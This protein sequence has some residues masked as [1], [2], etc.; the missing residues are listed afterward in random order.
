MMTLNMNHFSIIRLEAAL[1]REESQ[2]L[3]LLNSNKVG[4]WKM[5]S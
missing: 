3:Y 1:E 4:I 5:L 2:G